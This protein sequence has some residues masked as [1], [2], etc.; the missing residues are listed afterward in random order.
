MEKYLNYASRHLEPTLKNLCGKVQNC[1]EKCGILTTTMA[2]R[3]I[4]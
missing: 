3:P 1:V 2:L 4:A